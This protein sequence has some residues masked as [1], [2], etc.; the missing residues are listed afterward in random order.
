MAIDLSLLITGR[1]TTCQAQKSKA[2]VLGKLFPPHLAHL[3]S[4]TLM[5][6]AIIAPLRGLQAQVPSGEAD[7]DDERGDG[8]ALEADCG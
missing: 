5:C 8:G 6:V 3:F 1:S 4:L 2:G 7:G